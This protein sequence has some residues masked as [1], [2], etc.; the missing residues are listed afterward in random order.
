M[1]PAY[2]YELRGT[3]AQYDVP[4][5][6]NFT[7]SIYLPLRGLPVAQHISAVVLSKFVIDLP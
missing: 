6:E 3:I 1:R 2:E 4:V 5:P 7:R